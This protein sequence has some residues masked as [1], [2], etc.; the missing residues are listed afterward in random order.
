MRET[1]TENI[2]MSTPGEMDI[3]EIIQSLALATSTID[4]YVAGKKNIT[5]DEI[6]FLP[7]TLGRAR[8]ILLDM[9][10][11]NS[12]SE[13]EKAEVQHIINGYNELQTLL[14]IL[15][16]GIIIT[17]DAQN[18][19]MTINL[20]GTQMLNLQPG[21]NPA[22]M[23]SDGEKLPFKIMRSGHE[24]PLEERPM[25]YA[26]KHQVALRDVELDIHQSNG[27]I[28]NLLEY[29]SPL[30]DDHGNV[31]G[32]VGVMVDITGRKSIEQQL[33][34]QY[35]IA[36]VL[37][38]SNNIN[39]A[40][41]QVLKMI[42]EVA[43]WEYGTLWRVDSD[44][45]TLTNKGVWHA[46]NGNL[47]QYAE[48]ICYSVI[49]LDDTSLPGYVFHSGQ[50]LWLSNISEFTSHS[51]YVAQ[52]QNA[53]LQSAFVVPI[54]SG[55]RVIAILECLSTR[56]QAQDQNLTSMLNA[57]GNQIGIFL[58]RKLLEETLAIRANQ[59]NMLAEVGMILST[60]LDY[61]KRLRTIVRLVV[62]ELADW[63]AIDIID[64]E[65]VLRRVAAA[66][67]DPDKEK[68]LYQLQPT[69][70][71]D[72]N[73]PVDGQIGTLLTGKSLLFTDI[74]PSLIEK[75]VSD[76]EKIKMIRQLDPVS[77]IIVPLIA[78][79]RIMGTVTFVQS[80]SRRRYFASDLA[81]A[82][83][84]VQ[85]VA[86]A[87]D[88]A[89]LYAESQKLNL[90]LERHVDERTAQLKSAIN[91]LTNQIAERQHAE[92]Q[93][94]NLNSE[95]EQRIVERTSQLER[96]NLDLHKEIQDRQKAS[97][98]LGI[99]LR[100][101][102]ELYHISQSI[103][104][105]RTPD[106]V[107]KVLLSSSYLKDV[108]RAS[109]GILEK[110]WLED[111]DPP[112]HCLI[113]AEWNRGTSLPRFFG[114]NFT[115]EEYGV[116]LP[117]PYGQPYVIQDIQ[118]T[119]K[120]SKPVR[121]RFAALRTHS[122]IIVPLI[123]GGEWYGLLSLHFKKH[124]MTNLD[125][126]RHVRGLVDETAIAI[127]NM[128]LLEAESQARHEAE[129]ANDLKL[130]F[131]AMISHELRTPLT[132]IKGFA[133][134][135]LADDVVWSPEKYR[136]FLQ[137]INRESDKLGDLI[138]QLLDLTRM[139]AGVLRISAKKVSLNSIF[140]TAYP[141]LLT[142][143]PT[144]EL[145][146]NIPPELPPI[147]GDPQR[148]AQVLTNLVGN[149]AKFSP[150]DTQIEITIRQQDEMI[151]ID[152]A[153][154]GIGIPPEEYAH[155]FESFRQLENGSGVIKKGAG[156]GLAICK[157]LIEAQKGKI[158]IQE[159]KGPGTIISFTLPIVNEVKKTDEKPQ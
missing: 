25:N 31:S 152:V 91:E 97:E 118:S 135:L 108:S 149:A 28:L 36:R 111:E 50:P 127:K 143:T 13:T 57:V 51:Q 102:R 159:H 89:M 158:W 133:T 2:T 130:R 87:L 157:G 61:E 3:R 35:E 101:T 21:A 43:R 77:F 129:K 69:R 139:E 67:T 34:M 70:K 72:L 109:I 153:D 88:N 1:Q 59:Q 27:T 125:D 142:L 92:E 39:H 124:R 154:Q 10:S 65:Q 128:R 49:N 23:I 119:E 74:P 76:P 66:H 100:R 121:K 22:K 95:L 52:A 112:E 45:S 63:C 147:F 15:P 58:E 131:L 94:K 18:Q 7:A 83:S 26:V 150:P 71:V 40:A 14:E 37:A 132:S 11:Q 44:A 123:A 122:L 116:I 99:L 156:L 12:Q 73:Q 46:E 148:I 84:I 82:E 16:I 47:T 144:Q 138:E 48:D 33:V 81:F 134:T 104:T 155:V 120:L 90:E 53:G 30:Y 62:P 85:R 41:T 9:E 4:S 141:Q 29:V 140:D 126:L 19:D 145:I 56:N 60:S 86:L 20:S 98:S 113:L 8:Q 75:T 54:H 146:L 115:L 55:E 137:I 105:V 93:I 17:R 78:H 6:S 117:A 151:Q 38:E 114:H 106:E 110:P 24:L 107:L 68:L 103:G 136:D 64:K 79:D 42:C 32:C 96:A 80:D 5:K